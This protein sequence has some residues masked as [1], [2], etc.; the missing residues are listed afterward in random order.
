MASTT[1]LRRLALIALYQIDARGDED[2][3]AIRESLEDEHALEEEGWPF[4]EEDV[5]FKPAERERALGLAQAAWD[6]RA[7]A[8][9]AFER[10]AP[11]WPSRR[12]AAVDRAVLRLAY[13]ELAGA[14]APRKVIIDEATTMAASFGGEK[15][16]GFVNGLLAALEIPTGAGG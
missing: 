13:H 15:S 2:L 1:D 16:P 12:L 8:D 5:A 11:E 4:V 7:D 6:G 3:D 10:L 14:T 9:A